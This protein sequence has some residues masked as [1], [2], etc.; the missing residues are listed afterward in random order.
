MKKKLF[1]VLTKVSRPPKRKT[2]QPSVPYHV[3]SLH[4]R[5]LASG[6]SNPLL[7]KAPWNSAASS[8]TSCRTKPRKRTTS[9]TCAK[10]RTS[11]KKKNF[12]LFR[13]L[14]TIS[15]WMVF[16]LSKNKN[17]QKKHGKNHTIPISSPVFR[18][19]D[20]NSAHSAAPPRFGPRETPHL[21]P[22]VQQI[23]TNSN[24]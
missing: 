14:V 8:R 11:K 4:I 10:T 7:G 5:L 16:Y 24:S 21:A 20:H 23:S 9:C 17:L 19:D 22:G 6:H 12:K 3:C 15:F 2:C 1:S 13:L 18:S